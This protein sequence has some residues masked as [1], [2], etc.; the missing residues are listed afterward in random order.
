[1]AMSR[2]TKEIVNHSLKKLS[3]KKQEVLKKH[4]YEN[5]TG[6]E[7]AVELGENY[8]RVKQRIYRALGELEELLPIEIGECC[9]DILPEEY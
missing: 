2:N 5:K 6:P 3:P 8:E 1:M 7:I 4:F 9:G